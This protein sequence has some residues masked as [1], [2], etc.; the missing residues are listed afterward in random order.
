MLLKVRGTLP[1]GLSWATMSSSTPSQPEGYFSRTSAG[2]KSHKTGPRF[3]TPADGAADDARFHVAALRRLQH[4]FVEASYGARSRCRE[5]QVF[6]DQL[7]RDA[8]F[9]S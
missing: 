7:W 6:L 4:A 5:M 9:C 8:A 2:S 1:L 3:A